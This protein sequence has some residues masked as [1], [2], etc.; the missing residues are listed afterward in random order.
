[1]TMNHMDSKFNIHM[2]GLS[3]LIV[4]THCHP[5]LVLPIHKLFAPFIYLIDG[6]PFF[7]C[8]G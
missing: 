3:E 2:I 6:L 7:L 8:M 5:P 4:I 1:M